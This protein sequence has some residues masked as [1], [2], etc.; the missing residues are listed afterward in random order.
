M[1]IS[2]SAFLSL[3]TRFHLS[4]PR[5]RHMTNAHSTSSEL[6]LSLSLHPSPLPFSSL[7]AAQSSLSVF[8]QRGAQC[9]HEATT[10]TGDTHSETKYAC[11]G[12]RL[13]GTARSTDA[14]AKECAA[15]R[16]VTHARAPDLQLHRDATRTKQIINNNDRRCTASCVAIPRNPR[17]YLRLPVCMPMHFGR[18]YSSAE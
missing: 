11:E 6:S 9:T 1:H 16:N 14:H 18:K 15:R 12:T 13:Y 5:V 3:S 10:G 8:V 2:L 7:G 17:L 4:N